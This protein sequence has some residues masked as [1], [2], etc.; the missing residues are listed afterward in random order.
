MLLKSQKYKICVCTP[1]H[2]KIPRDNVSERMLQFRRVQNSTWRWPERKAWRRSWLKWRVKRN[3]TNTSSKKTV[4][5]LGFWFGLLIIVN[6][7]YQVTDCFHQICIN[8]K[9]FQAGFQISIQHELMVF[10][11]EYLLEWILNS[12]SM[13]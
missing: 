7:Q 2:Q 12:I 10:V 9:Y 4:T 6:V 1:S 3:F 13:K 11:S 5:L 8:I